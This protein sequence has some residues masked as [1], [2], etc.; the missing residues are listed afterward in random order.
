MRV[1]I[2]HNHYQ[3]RGGEDAVVE[4]EAAALAE[5][6]CTVETLAFHND[7][8]RTAIDRLRTAFEAPHAPR[9]IA[10]VVEAVRRFRPDVVHAHN[11]FPLISPA[12]HGAVRALGPVTVQTLHNFR[13]ACA[14]AMLMRDGAPCETCL[15]GSSYAAVRH[16]CY[17][18]SRLGTLAVARMIDR[19]RR[20][21]TWTRDVDAFVALTEFARGRFVA[22]G[23]PA[24]RIFVKPNGLPDPGQPDAGPRDGILFAGRLSPEKGVEI[25]KQAAARL[26][27]PVDVAGEGPLRE[28]LEGAPGLTL[29][30]ALPRGAMRTRIG[31]AAALVVPSLWYEG[32]PMVV[33]EAFAAGTPVIASRIG[34]L[35]HLVEDGVTGLLVAPGDPAA[36]AEAIERLRGRPEEARRMGAAA[37][38]A[39]LRDWTEEATTAALLTI[40]RKALAA[41]QRDRRVSA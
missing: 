16:G 7:D 4:H 10:R 3:I 19:H 40:Y 27:A 32:L 35:A 6:G 11:T 9:G 12:V 2:V 1:L 39:Y 8:I 17:R 34:A 25:L 41:R 37:R 20:T 38:A 36:L 31:R 23:L 13:L 14:G 15:T 33:A 18:G 28:R 5:A 26:A 30:G 22:A 29:L 24:H 21:G